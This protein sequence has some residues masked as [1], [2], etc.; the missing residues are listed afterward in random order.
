MYS[1]YINT[2]SKLTVLYEHTFEI[3]WLSCH[4]LAPVRTEVSWNVGW[5]DGPIL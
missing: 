5:S 4:C 3:V 1:N 2:K